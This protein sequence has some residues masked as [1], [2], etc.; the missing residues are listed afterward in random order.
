MKQN[1]FN[2]IF[3]PLLK[4]NNWKPLL[5]R[6]TKKVSKLFKNGKKYT[7][8]QGTIASDIAHRVPELGI[9]A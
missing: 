9:F 3:C 2:G 6:K 5:F 7:K 1:A 4:T 8:Q